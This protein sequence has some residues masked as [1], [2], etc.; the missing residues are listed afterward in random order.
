LVKGGGRGKGRFK[1]LV[2]ATTTTNVKREKK[3]VGLGKKNIFE[4]IEL[5]IQ[6][7][8]SVSLPYHLLRH[9]SSSSSTAFIHSYNKLNTMMHLVPSI[10]PTRV[11]KVKVYLSYALHHP[12]FFLIRYGTREPL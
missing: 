9:S 10:I 8:S 6:P 1:L 4:T 3:K 11:G 5:L 7:A 12:L 2:S